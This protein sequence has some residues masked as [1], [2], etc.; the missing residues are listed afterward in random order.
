MMK[1]VVH[2]RKSIRL[3]G[4]DYSQEGGY[5]VTICTKNRASVFGDVVDGE[6]RL[7]T[8]GEIAGQCLVEIPIH[9]P[10][11]VLDEF[12][13]LPNHVHGILKWFDGLS[14]PG[15]EVPSA[16]NVPTQINGRGL[17]NQTPTKEWILMKNPK[18]TLGKIIRSY[19]AKTTR[20]I[21]TSI[22]FDFRWQR[23][24][25]ERIIRNEEELFRIRRYI[26]ENVFR[27]YL[28]DEHAVEMIHRKG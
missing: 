11:V 26:A 28:D 14:S 7:S 23:G 4:Y 1:R 6:M 27:W 22:D 19:K 3:K 17:I 15:M 20:L 18:Q 9:F 5:F 25:Y 2:N 21:H 8:V 13:I 12:T 10:N 16:K 24:F